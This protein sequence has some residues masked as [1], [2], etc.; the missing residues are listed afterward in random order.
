MN[1]KGSSWW[2]IV[3][4]TWRWKAA[5]LTLRASKRRSERD[6]GVG[7]MYLADLADTLSVFCSSHVISGHGVLQSYLKHLK[8]FSVVEVRKERCAAPSCGAAVMFIAQ[9]TTFGE[10]DKVPCGVR[11]NPAPDIPGIRE[12]TCVNMD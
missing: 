12:V 6:G 2:R 10:E 5:G 4:P 1:E 9:A 8:L 7:D 11:N 3:E